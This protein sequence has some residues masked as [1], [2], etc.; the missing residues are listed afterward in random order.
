MHVPAGVPH[1][2]T[3]ARSSCSLHLSELPHIYV[4]VLIF[5]SCHL[6]FFILFFMM[7]YMQDWYFMEV[8]YSLVGINWVS[9]FFRY[10]SSW[11][12]TLFSTTL[13]Q[14][15]ACRVMDSFLVDGI[16]VIFRIALACLTLGKE[17]LFC[18]DMEGMLKVWEK[19]LWFNTSIASFWEFCKNCSYV[20]SISF[21]SI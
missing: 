21:C 7:I 1:T 20:F 9:L 16:E 17:D 12:L 13:P 11:F 4:S 3:S 2:R 5:F 18:M 6:L 8:K 19:Q 14:P 15:L 10:A